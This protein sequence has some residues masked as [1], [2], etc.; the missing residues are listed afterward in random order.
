[1]DISNYDNNYSDYNFISY[2]D[3]LFVQVNLAYMKK[4][5]DNIDHFVGDDIY[6][7]LKVKLEK[8]GN[9]TEMFDEMNVK[10]TE[11]INKK[12]ED[13]NIIIDVKLVSRSVNYIID[14]SGKVI[15]G[16]S[17]NR[18]EKTNILTFVKKVNAVN[19]IARHCP[20]CG[21]NIDVNRNGKC[22]YCG[23]IYDLEN[24]DFVLVK[25]EVL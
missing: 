21:G 8:L 23:S 7:L 6:N 17:N 4:E 16:D 18:I 1:M 20:S 13:N 15:S 5:I 3:N 19:T 14:S 24:H 22:P 11:I 25:W 9:N 10:S 2:V 12:V